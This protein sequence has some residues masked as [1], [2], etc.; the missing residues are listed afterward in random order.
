MPIQAEQPDY[1]ANGHPGGGGY[2]EVLRL[3]VE[4]VD[5]WFL[6]SYVDDVDGERYRFRE[7]LSAEQARAGVRSESGRRRLPC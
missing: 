5:R 4:G 3:K 7:Y 2:L 1:A 6:Q